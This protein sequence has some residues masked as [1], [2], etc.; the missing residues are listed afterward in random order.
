MQIKSE[1]FPKLKY[2]NFINTFLGEPFVD[3]GEKPKIEAIITR[4]RRYHIDTLPKDAQ[5]LLVTIGADVQADRIECEVVAWGAGAESWSINY[6]VISGDTADPQDEM[7][8]TL[9]EIVTSEHAGF[10]PVLTGIDSGFR[11]DLVYEFAD[12]FEAG[13]HPVMGFDKLGQGREYIK[14]H[15]VGGRSTPRIDVN[16]DL[17]K[18]QVYSWLNKGEYESGKKPKGYC[19]F[20]VEY[21]REHFNRLTAESRIRVD[22]GGAVKYKWDAGKRRNE[23]LDCRVYALAMVYAFRMYIEQETGVDDMPWDDFWNY[24]AEQEAA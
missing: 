12:S 7:W 14:P 19:H 24:L 9:R 16:T 22:S 2:Q 6:F 8:D 13:V 1:G 23:Q 10:V 11:T 17:L 4:H 18:Q 21:S 5:P 20:P 15:T 3:E